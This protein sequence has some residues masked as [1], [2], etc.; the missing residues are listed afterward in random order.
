MAAKMSKK[1]KRAIVI[2]AV[3]AAAIIAGVL[4]AVLRDNKKLEVETVKVETQT[5][6]ETLDTMGTVSAGSQEIFTIPNGVKV[7]S[8]NV[9]EGD[10][11]KAGDIIAT[12]DISSLNESLNQKESAFEQANAAYKNA[13]AASNGSGGKA[14]ELKKQISK[15]E[16]EISEL[17]S[18]PPVQPA[19]CSTP[20]RGYYWLCP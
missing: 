17:E 13:V 10:A 1:K 9:K 20:V 19:V 18:K 2:A 16:K 6:N 11:V 5:V 8:L 3:L 4:F 14:A 12:F 7:T 15:L